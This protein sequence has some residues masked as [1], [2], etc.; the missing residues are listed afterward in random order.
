VTTD[1][2]ARAESAARDVERSGPVRALARLGLAARGLVWLVIGL[3]ALSVLL[4]GSE[5]TDQGGAL[6]EVA[7]QP[8]GT[9]L[10]VVL[11]IGFFGHALWRLLQ[12]AVGHSGE[13]GAKRWAKRAESLLRGLVYAALGVAVV[14]FL[15]AGDSSDKTQSVTADLMAASGGRWLVG[16]AG[17]AVLGIGAAM[18]V[19]GVRQDHAEELE[20]WR[21]PSGLRRPA[22]RVGIVGQIGRGTVVGLVGVFLLR[23][24]WQFDPR[25]AKGLDAV[26]ASVA[27]QPYGQV[28]LALAVVGV[29]AFAVWSFVEA[30]YKRL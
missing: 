11:A 30:L 10:L 14:R 17:L 22:V 15:T 19:K 26:L 21:M 1:S 20:S 7:D 9:A 5:Q 12:A 16:L 6:R 8:F 2:A 23:A 3:L 29:L 28:L 27:A 18:I 24:A 25:E 4:G 13:D